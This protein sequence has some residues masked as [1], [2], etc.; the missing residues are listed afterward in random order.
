M[1]RCQATAAIRYN[2]SS[3]GEKSFAWHWS[4]RNCQQQAYNLR[5]IWMTCPL[6]QRRQ[7][8]LCGIMM[9]SRS[10][11]VQ[12][13]INWNIWSSQ[14]EARMN[15]WMK[16]RQNDISKF[17]IAIYRKFRYFCGRYDTIYRYRI[18]ISIFSIYRY[19]TSSFDVLFSDTTKHHI[20]HTI[21]T[22]RVLLCGV[23]CWL[24]PWEYF[25]HFAYIA[26]ALHCGK[27]HVQSLTERA[28]LNPWH[29]NTWIFL[30]IWTWH[31]SLTLWCLTDFRAFK[32]RGRSHP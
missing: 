14:I 12:W 21:H 3:F 32:G 10:I 29:K 25:L 20:V 8:W 27:A 17:D 24:T 16:I 13:L 11:I 1:R 23:N 26:V 4:S 19:S 7:N 28:N 5:Q 6:L 2:M 22:P 9:R 15:K 30:Q 18:D 31:P